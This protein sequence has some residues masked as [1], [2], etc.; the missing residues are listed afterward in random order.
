MN[1]LTYLELTGQTRTHIEQ[2]LEPRF[3]AHPEVVEAFFKMRKAALKD[4]FNLMP[5]S[6]SFRDFKTQCRIWNMK[7]LGKKPLYDENGQVRKLFAQYH[8]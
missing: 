3:A 8:S 4:G 6:C 7:F 2:L 5:F 1:K